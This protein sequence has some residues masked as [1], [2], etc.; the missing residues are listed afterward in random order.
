M[1]LARHTSEETR[2][3]RCDGLDCFEVLVSKRGNDCKRKFYCRE[4]RGYFNP[5]AKPKCRRGE[6]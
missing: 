1:G 6:K 2:G 5:Y 3:L 4:I